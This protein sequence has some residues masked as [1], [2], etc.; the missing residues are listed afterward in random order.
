MKNKITKFGLAV[1]VSLTLSQAVNGQTP[2]ARRGGP[3]PAA[4]AGPA[5]RGGAA[6]S[7]LEQG[8]GNLNLSEAKRQEI[9]AA[10]RVEQQNVR[11]LIE[12]A[13]ADLV[14]KMKE[15]V[16]PTEFKKLTDSVAALRAAPRGNGANVTEDDLV[17]RVLSFDKSGT[18]RI[19][20]DDLPERMQSLVAEGDSNNDQVLDREEIKNLASDRPTAAAG[21]RGGRGA[22][23]PA[24]LA[25]PA[26]AISAVAV[27][28]VIGGLN[29][30]G[31][32]KEAAATLIRTE[33]ETLVKLSALARSELLLKADEVLADD[34]FKSFTA[35]LE[36]PPQVANNPA[37]RRGGPPANVPPRGAGRGRGG[38]RG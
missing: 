16:S 17:T 8:V 36:R 21:R 34:E 9:V 25:A 23:N 3:P 27:E 2:N 30:M 4:P 31:A 26:N 19:T 1:V 35:L 12:L 18:G 28:R 6:P 38:N 7:P 14:M 11:A 22:A 32:A 13:N 5:R 15:V 29:L 24:G 10:I 20:K 33:Q 37:I